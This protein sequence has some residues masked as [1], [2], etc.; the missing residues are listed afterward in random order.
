MQDPEESVEVETEESSVT[1]E[2]VT[3]VKAEIE[4]EITP[5]PVPESVVVVEPKPKL[6]SD[7]VTVKILTG[8][9]KFGKGTFQRGAEIEV[10]RA[11]AARFGEAAQIIKE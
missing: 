5:A 2:E 8:T 4:P 3:E 10:T 1:V 7:I 6:D 9:L 11:E